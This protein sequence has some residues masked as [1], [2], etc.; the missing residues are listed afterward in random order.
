VRLICVSYVREISGRKKV[1][2]LHEGGF[3][4]VERREEREK[5]VEGERSLHGGERR[6]PCDPRPRKGAVCGLRPSH[7]WPAFGSS[8]FAEFAGQGVAGFGFAS[9]AKKGIRLGGVVVCELRRR[10]GD[11]GLRVSQGL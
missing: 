2:E 6:R 5:V 1:V 4:L 3:L 10:R 8:E 9:F 11:L 7:G